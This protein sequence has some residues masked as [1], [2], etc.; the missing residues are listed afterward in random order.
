MEK[1][2]KKV[3]S[4]VLVISLFNWFGSFKVEAQG[5]RKI[6]SLEKR[7]ETLEKKEKSRYKKE[8]KEILTYYKNG[9]KMRTRDN[10]FRA[11]MG[12]RIMHDWGFFSESG[13]FKS[14]FA[15]ELESML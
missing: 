3:F 8:E 1:I 2:I 5:S 9:F 7:L 13:S 14:T 10:Q 4:L 12:G 11:Q 6:E 15:S